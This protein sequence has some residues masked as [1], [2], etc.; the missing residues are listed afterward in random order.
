MNA[1]GALSVVVL[2]CHGAEQH[3]LVN[4]L[5]E[6][7]KLEAVVFECRGAALRRILLRR[8]RT[9]GPITVANQMLYKALDEAFF[10]RSARIEAEKTFGDA[11]RV[12]KEKFPGVSIRE[13]ESVNSPDV[14]TLLSEISPDAIVVSG[15]SLLGKA[16]LDAVGEAPILN[17]HCGITP[18]YRGA[19]GAYWAVVND[20]WDNA[21]TTVHFIDEGVDTGGVVA[22]RSIAVERGDNPRTLALK[23]NIAG[24]ELVLEALE[25]LK[26][27]P[28][29]TLTRSDL[30][31]RLYYSPTLTS[32]V[33]YRSNLARRLSARP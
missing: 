25:R 27:G 6:R 5:A 26:S 19:H 9:L 7:H 12:E 4:T 17:I 8:L 18:R 14:V 28:L 13:T 10:K 24:I 33:T 20:D 11:A 21:G 31:S 22:Q 29:P 2:A 3:A 15:T 30:D 1:Q 23:Q 32:Y 16:V